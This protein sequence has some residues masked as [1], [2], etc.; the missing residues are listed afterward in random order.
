MFFVPISHLPL[1]FIK[2]Q[3]SEGSNEIWKQALIRD[4]Q[5]SELRDDPSE[6]ECSIVHHLQTLAIAEHILKDEEQEDTNNDYVVSSSVFGLSGN[7]NVIT[8]SSA[9]ISWK[10]WNKASRV[11]YRGSKDP[12]ANLNGPCK[13]WN[14]FVMFRQYTVALSS[15]RIAHFSA[16]TA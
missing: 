14:L 8:A 7:E 15:L 11:F 1:L 5:F 10:Q 13:W 12:G 16:S 4:F 9:F 2:S 3:K 6:D